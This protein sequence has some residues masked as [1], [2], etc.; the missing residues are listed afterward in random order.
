MSNETEELVKHLRK[1][2]NSLEIEVDNEHADFDIVDH[3]LVGKIRESA[4]TIEAQQR[5]IA[6]IEADLKDKNLIIAQ[7]DA[8]IIELRDE[9]EK[10]RSAANG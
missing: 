9:N 4:D 2:S 8:E 6:A 1:I 10:L 5:E 7:Q 3:Y